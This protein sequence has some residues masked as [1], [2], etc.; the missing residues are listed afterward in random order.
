MAVISC[1]LAI[2]EKHI[3]AAK[4]VRTFHCLG[5]HSVRHRW[6]AIAETELKVLSEQR[7][8]GA[9]EDPAAEMLPTPTPFL[10]SEPLVTIWEEP[11]RLCTPSART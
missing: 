5:V 8:D 1:G 10:G 3:C 6:A 4:Q 9:K 2:R 7:A 11:P